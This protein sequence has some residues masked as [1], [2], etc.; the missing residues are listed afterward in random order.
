MNKSAQDSLNTIDAFLN[1]VGGEEKSASAMSEP[2]SQGGETSH[3]VK[4]VDDRLQDAPEGERSSENS[5]DV[6]EDQGEPSVENAPEAKAKVAKDGKS[7]KTKKAEGVSEGTAAEDHLQLGTNVQATGDDPENETS[8]T[9]PGKEDG[10]YDGASSHPARTD[11]DELDGHKYAGDLNKDPLEKL[12]AEMQDLG[13]ALCADITTDQSGESKQAG[14]SGK[15]GKQGEAGKQKSAA[16]SQ[17]KEA[18]GEIDPNLAAQV[19]WEMAG[20]MTGNFDKQAADSLVQGTLVQTIKT[21]SDDAD[22]VAAYLQARTK[23][24][25]GEEESAPPAGESEES[26]GGEASGGEPPAPPAGGG[27]DPLSAMGG[28]PPAPPAGGGGGDALAQLQGLL[29]QLGVTPE[30][31]M[32][33]LAAGE[34]GGAPP[35]DGGAP[36]M[37]GGAPPMGGGAPPAAPPAEPPMGGGAPPMGGMEVAAGDK[38]GKPAPM[39][40][41]KQAEVAAYLREVVGRSRAKQAATQKD[42]SKPAA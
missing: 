20:L 22:R 35:M 39:T 25:E 10:Q 27:G 9:K 11:N 5:A 41:E 29:D 32:A 28:E 1:E 12:A 40:P 4:D 14:D 34:G 30:E 15:P 16:D 19:G 18:S 37:G 17:E 21:A 24:A 6:K 3:P 8:G 36:P 7:G 42:A 23:Q 31:L 33:A 2:G 38:G 13:N 26:E